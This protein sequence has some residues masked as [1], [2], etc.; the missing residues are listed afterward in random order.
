MKVPFLNL[1]AINRQYQTEFS[2]AQQ[3]VLDSGWFIMG[4][5]L[6]AFEKEFAA[7]LA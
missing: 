4:P 2:S 3:A 5:Q 6:E 7:R 1:G